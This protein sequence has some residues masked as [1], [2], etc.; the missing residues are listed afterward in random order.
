M[1]LL[2][3]DHFLGP[4]AASSHPGG[5]PSP[6]L[7]QAMLSE[8]PALPTEGLLWSRAARAKT[9]LSLHI[10]QP[11]DRFLLDIVYPPAP[12]WRD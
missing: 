7:F 5:S 9:S 3:D 11:T 6:S 12:G 8:L 1:S 10:S 4:R 2:L